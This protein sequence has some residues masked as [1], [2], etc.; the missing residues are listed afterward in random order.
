MNSDVKAFTAIVIAAMVCATAV[1]AVV[2]HEWSGPFLKC[3]G[4]QTNEPMPV[5]EC[6]RIMCGSN[7]GCKI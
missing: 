2:F 6:L 7:K 3:V 4:E 5:T 1:F